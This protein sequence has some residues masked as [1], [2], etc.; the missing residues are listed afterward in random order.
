M[1]AEVGTLPVRTLSVLLAQ[2]V[3]ASRRATAELLAE[4]G[5]DVAV[6]ATGY[7]AVRAVSGAD[8]DVVL[9]SVRMPEMDGLTATRLIRAADSVLPGW[10][11][12][13]VALTGDAK[14]SD[15]EACLAAGCNGC[16]ARPLTR[17]K[18][19]TVLGRMTATYAGTSTDALGGV[20]AAAVLPPSEAG[21]EEL[22]EAFGGDIEFLRPVAAAFLVSLDGMLEA[23]WR[24][25]ETGDAEGLA[26]AGHSLKGVV[27]L[28]GDTCAGDAARAV[29]TFAR[30][31]RLAAGAEAARGLDA[32]VGRLS[33]R[34]ASLLQ[35]I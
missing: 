23:M 8:F 2:S 24:S 28:F 17:D 30:Q 32:L 1:N 34:L 11:V 26:R 9:M 12:P 5:H 29:E 13:I 3:S 7:E 15:L 35:C 21:T 16:L 33:R 31:G 10:Q 4:D 25:V 6:A 27:E 18:L 20:C 19:R 22:I 14:D